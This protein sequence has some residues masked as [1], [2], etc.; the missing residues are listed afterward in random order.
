[1]AASIAQKAP[2]LIP[3]IAAPRSMTQ[4]T[5]WTDLLYKPAAYGA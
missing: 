2:A 1:M 3:Q 4:S 5:L